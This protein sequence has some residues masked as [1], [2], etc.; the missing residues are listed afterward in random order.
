MQPLSSSDSESVRNPCRI[1]PSLASG[2]NFEAFLG[3]AQ[4]NLRT[5]Q[6][7]S[8]VRGSEELRGAAGSSG[9]LRR[10]RA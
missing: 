9:E 4:F 7:I 10:A 5:P 1:H 6:A 2:T 8:Q 3:P